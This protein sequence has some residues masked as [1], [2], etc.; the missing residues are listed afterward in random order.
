MLIISTFVTCKKA[1][2]QKDIRQD[3]QEKTINYERR[4]WNLSTGEIFTAIK[5][6][7]EQVKSSRNANS[8]SLN[9]PTITLDS[10]RV[11]SALW[12][13]ECCLN[14]DFDK[15]T[16][17]DSVSNSVDMTGLSDEYATS[18]TGYIHTSDL[19]EVYNYFTDHCNDLIDPSNGYKRIKIIDIYT[20]DVSSGI[21]FGSN[22]VVLN[23]RPGYP[24]VY[25]C[26]A[27]SNQSF[28]WSLAL[29]GSCSSNT[30]DAV[31]N[32][33]SRLNCIN[34]NGIGCYNGWVTWFPPIGIDVFN[35]FNNNYSSA[36]YRKVDNLSCD[37]STINST[38]MN[39][40]VSGCINLAVNSSLWPSYSG[41]GPQVTI[42]NYNIS[43]TQQVNGSGV[44]THWWYEGVFF[45][46]PYCN[47]ETN[48]Y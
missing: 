22:V 30:D 28:I 37:N 1:G 48:L 12:M 45:G 26:D 47:L 31:L 7:K 18:S 2:E 16:A 27:F 10:L 32:M 17:I 46:R 34:V 25:Y 13:L 8:K 35:N 39:S 24:F 38:Q 36:L 6:F 23:G 33:T 29:G 9:L 5:K 40:F 43:A 44:Y 11:D 19:I 41:P 15:C 21:A 42:S 14:F 4:M 3:S 20:K